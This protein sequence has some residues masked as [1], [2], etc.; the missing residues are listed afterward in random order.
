MVVATATATVEDDVD[1]EDASGLTAANG[2]SGKLSKKA[3]LQKSLAA[4]RAKI[5]QSCTLNRCEVNSKATRM[6]TDDAAAQERKR[7]NKQD[8]SARQEEY[9]VYVVGKLRDGAA[10]DDGDPKASGS[11]SGGGGKVGQKKLVSLFQPVYN[12]IRQMNARAKKEERSPQPGR[13]L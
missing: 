5:N 8:R 7:Q 11:T 13:L 1:R 9:D 3:A 12:S 2:N 10:A 6:G 4:L